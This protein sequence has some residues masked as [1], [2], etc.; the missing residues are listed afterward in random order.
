MYKYKNVSK[1]VI[2][3]LKKEQVELA[4]KLSLIDKKDI[5]EIKYIAGIDT[6]FTNI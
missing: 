3:K 1:E 4:K 6:T 2:K 5:N